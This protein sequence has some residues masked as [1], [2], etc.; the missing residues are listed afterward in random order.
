MKAMI[1]LLVLLLGMGTLGLPADAQ[2]ERLPQTPENKRAVY[3]QVAQRTKVPW[4]YLAA[5]HQY[6]CALHR[7][8]KSRGEGDIAWNPDLWTGV[9]NPDRTDHTEATIRLYGGIGRDGS[10]DGIADPN[11]LLDSLYTMGMYLS[12]FGTSDKDIPIALWN[13]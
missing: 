5:I 6:E 12:R 10:G 2:T 13:Y 1:L 7:K 11:N 4:Y 8:N 9:L 3:Q